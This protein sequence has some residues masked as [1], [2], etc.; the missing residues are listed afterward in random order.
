MLPWRRSAPDI[1][2]GFEEL[3]V[4][5]FRSRSISDIVREPNELSSTPPR[6]RASSDIM[7]E[8]ETAS[9]EDLLER[10]EQGKAEI[11]RRDTK[12]D[13]LKVENQERQAKNT[14]LMGRLQA[15]LD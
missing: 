1:N 15:S 8:L 9:P 12:C 10:I 4:R 14:E 2:K 3:P 6:P 7:R 13:E 11:K 5:F